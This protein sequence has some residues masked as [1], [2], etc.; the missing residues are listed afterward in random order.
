MPPHAFPRR[1]LLLG[2]VAASTVA[3]CSGAEP[4]LYVLAPMEPDE[5]AKRGGNRSIG[6]Q[7]VSLPEYLDRSEI[8]THTSANELRANRDDRW[9]ERLPNNVTRVL[10]ENLSTLLASDR[11]HVMPSRNGDRADYEVH[12]DIDRF[13]RAASGQSVLDARWTISDG[14]TQKVLVRDETR[15]ANRARDQGYPA[16]VAAMNDNLT[17]LSHEIAGAIAKLPQ[18]GG[19]RASS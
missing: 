12:V 6:V 10:A 8:V 5:V 19:R 7:L 11:V 18:K 17:V 15:L 9:A 13:E 14:A 16:L 1:W 4:R 3:G 2:L